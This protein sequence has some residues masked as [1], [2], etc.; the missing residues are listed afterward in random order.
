[1]FT[2]TMPAE[3]SKSNRPNVWSSV[4]V[5]GS[6]GCPVGCVLT[7]LVSLCLGFV[8]VCLMPFDTAF[9]GGIAGFVVIW[10]TAIAARLLGKRP[11]LLLFMGELVAVAIALNAFFAYDTPKHIIRT[12][13]INPIPQSLHIRRAHWEPHPMDPSAWIEFEAMPED[14]LL[15]I[16][17]N[18]FRL[19]VDAV[20][21][22]HIPDSLPQVSPDWWAPSRLGPNATL[23]TREFRHSVHT[24]YVAYEIGMWLNSQSNKACG[25]YQSF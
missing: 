19:R 5:T 17:T 13:F 7:L 20:P 21:H 6:L 12:Y 1:M 24:N 4:I 2:S 14:M 23:Y 9:L 8:G 16:K 3:A 10:T 25:F 15:I 22:D 18:K 11:P